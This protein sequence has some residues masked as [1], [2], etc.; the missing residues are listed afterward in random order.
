MNEDFEL[1]LAIRD[2]NLKKLK[3]LLNQNKSLINK[4]YSG[5]NI[6]LFAS[7]SGRKKLVE[8]LVN[9]CPELINFDNKNGISPIHAVI[10]QGN[11]DIFIYLLDEYPHLLNKKDDNGNTI[12][13]NAVYKGNKDIVEYIL[14]KSI[15]LISEKNL[16][17]DTPVDW[18]I[19]YRNIE[20]I[21]FFKDIEASQNLYRN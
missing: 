6:L 8:Y 19:H 11:K 10:L 18:A 17:G 21:Q 16:Y 2:G 1:L 4:I 14:E 5:Q 20:L 13:H 7:E 12:L 9:K 15:N 3:K